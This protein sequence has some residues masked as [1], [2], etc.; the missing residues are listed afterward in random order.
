[1]LEY[2]MVVA[3]VVVILGGLFWFLWKGRELDR[4]QQNRQV[5][6]AEHAAQAHQKSTHPTRG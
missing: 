3:V 2:I 4:E 1:M 5:R 6:A